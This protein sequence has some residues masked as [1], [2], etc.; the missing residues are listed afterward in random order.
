MAVPESTSSFTSCGVTVLQVGA[1]QAGVVQAARDLAAG[2]HRD[3]HVQLAAEPELRDRLVPVAV[4]AAEHGE[5]TGDA[6]GALGQPPHV[7]LVDDVAVPDHR[8]DAGPLERVDHRVGVRRGQRRVAPVEDGRDA[9]VQRL[10]GTQQRGPPRIGR[11]ISVQRGTEHFR[12][13]ARH[14][15]V[16]ADAAQR[17]LPHVPVRVDEPRRHNQPGRVQHESVALD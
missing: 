5:R 8:P 13:V 7:G 16:D 6:A 12:E 3:D 9:R 1:E 10:E 15:H 4:L 2:V 11:R 17:C 14:R